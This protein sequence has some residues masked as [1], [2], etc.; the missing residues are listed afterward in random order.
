MH[1]KRKE[2]PSGRTRSDLETDRDE[3][4]I[5]TFKMALSVWAKIGLLSFG[6]PAGQIATMH[7]ELVEERRWIDESRFLHALNYCMLLPGPEAQQLA[8]Y[9]GW[10]LHKTR[11]GV[12]AGLLFILPGALTMLAISIAYV[13]MRELPGVEALFFGLKAA[14]LA[15]VTEAVL[16]IGRR[17]LKTR[18]MVMVALAAFLSLFLFGVPFPYVIAGAAL[19]GLLGSRLRPEYFPAP[20]KST[21]QDAGKTIVERVVLGAANAHTLPG[22][23]RA[24]VVLAV[25]GTLWVAPLVTIALVWGTSSVFFKQGVFFSQTAVVTFGGAYAVL[26]YIAQHA[27]EKYG[28]LVPGEM[29]DGLG[30]A[31]TTPGPLILVVQFVSFLGAYRHP[32]ELAPLWAGCLGAAITVWVTFVP[33]FL[34]IFLGAPYIEALRSKRALS[35]ALSTITAA[36]VGVI[37]NLSVWFFLNV[38]FYRTDEVDWGPLHLLVPD[39]RSVDWA[40]AALASVA[41][42]SM[43]KFKLGLPKTLLLSAVLGVGWRWISAGFLL[44]AITGCGSSPPPSA[45]ETWVG[46]VPL[47]HFAPLAADDDPLEGHRPATVDCNDLVGWYLEGD[48]LEIDTGACNYLALGAAAQVAVPKGAPISTTISHYDLTSDLPASAH[49]ALLLNDAVLW[50]ETIAVPTSA[51]V[52]EL[53]VPAPVAVEI[54]DVVS[55]HLHNHGQNSYKFQSLRVRASDVLER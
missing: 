18:L 43:L 40:A 6:G 34:W 8:V 21:E 9:I 42:L 16:R 5:P 44:A 15:V 30:L 48:A 27:V 47:S 1:P 37:L 31:E 23:G 35:V 2:A 51:G 3:I 25:C 41:L 46:L 49:I 13:S 38:V 17:A 45:E 11:G 36:V 20:T 29:L 33:C 14:V 22:V 39:L 24:M 12:A 54:G 26:S 19:L 50:Q 52:L 7:R 32:G 10:L 28:W 53:N 4:V 55:L